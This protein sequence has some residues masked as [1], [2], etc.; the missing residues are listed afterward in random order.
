MPDSMTSKLALA[1]SLKRLMSKQQLEKITVGDLCADCGI[2][3][4][5]FYYHFRD[6]YDLVNWI[7]DTE[8][9]SR[10]HTEA[11]ENLW[12]FYESICTYF[13]ENRL[14]Y[15]NAFAVQG[16]NSFSDYFS[17][18]IHPLARQR[19]M[20]TYGEGREYDFYATY[21]TDAIRVSL[22]RWLREQQDISPSEYARLI[23]RA[24]LAIAK[25]TQKESPDEA[26]PE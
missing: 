3:R 6:K 25:E 19:L 24:A 16:Q 11:D 13:F 21:F 8:V 10:L 4:K 23:R 12:T 5:G 1:E 18:V 26:E 7:F 22:V 14:F 17:E 20:E 9:T 2:S 15:I